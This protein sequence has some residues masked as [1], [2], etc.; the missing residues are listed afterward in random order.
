MASALIDLRLN[1]DNASRKL[2][3]I[4]HKLLGNGVEQIFATIT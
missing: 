1:S 3:G 4:L 2:D